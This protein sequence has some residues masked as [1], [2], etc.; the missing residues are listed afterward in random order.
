V[1]QKHTDTID[2]RQAGIRARLHRESERR[3]PDRPMLAGG[4]EVFEVADRTSATNHGG[5][6]LIHRLARRWG[7]R[8]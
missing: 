2:G 1:N 7:F 3:H 6:G 5:I 8:S 4:N